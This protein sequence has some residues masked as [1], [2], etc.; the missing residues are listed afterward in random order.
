MITKEKK[1]QIFDEYGQHDKDNGSTEVQI[2]VLTHRIRHLTTHCQKNKKDYSSMRGLLML[3]GRRRKLLAYLQK[4][5]LA[6][7]QELVERVGIRA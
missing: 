4:N 2:A 5:N 6:K 7:Y 3:V 1:K